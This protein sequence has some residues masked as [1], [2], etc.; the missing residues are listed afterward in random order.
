VS[1]SVQV[2]FSAETLNRSNSN[3][4]RHLL[5][6]MSLQ[7][8][9]T[10]FYFERKDNSCIS[11][12]DYTLLELMHTT[13]CLLCVDIISRTRCM[14][15][16]SMDINATSDRTSGQDLCSLM[17]VYKEKEVCVNIVL[18]ETCKLK[19]TPRL[20]SSGFIPF[21]SWMTHIF[22]EIILLSPPDSKM[23]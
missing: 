6:L 4:K 17:C 14:G 23:E 18:S 7:T 16:E 10:L 5:P 3:A 21:V 1:D 22:N 19:Q 9:Q 12:G 2:R 13:C 11:W 20:I 15:I 8:R